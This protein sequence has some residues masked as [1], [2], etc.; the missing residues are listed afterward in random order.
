MEIVHEQRSAQIASATRDRGGL[1][2]PLEPKQRKPEPN[3]SGRREEI[4]DG[5]YVAIVGF[6]AAECRGEFERVLGVRPAG[7]ACVADLSGN[8][9]IRG[10]AQEVRITFRGDIDERSNCR[11]IGV[12]KSNSNVLPVEAAALP[13]VE[14]L[15]HALPR[16]G[17]HAVGDPPAVVLRYGN[18]RHDAPGSFRNTPMIG[19]ALPIPPRPAADESG[20]PLQIR[21]RGTPDE[22][23]IPENPAILSRWLRFGHAQS[24]AGESFGFACD[25]T[26][27][28]SGSLS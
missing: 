14:G 11:M 9:D 25:V 13:A 22:G 18:Q 26:R 23:S 5:K 24:L 6:D 8:F 28:H 17:S 2:G 20:Q 3:S 12:A 7:A 19:R 21:K 16:V 27:S 15:G 4:R 1:S 10:W